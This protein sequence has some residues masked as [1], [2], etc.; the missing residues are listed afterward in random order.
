MKTCPQCGRELERVRQSENSPLN[1]DQFDA[2]KA[3]DWYCLAC[4]SNDRGNLP[5][6]YF[7]DYELEA[8]EKARIDAC[9]RV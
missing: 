8:F 6:S 3:G 7:W 1:R 4:P 2:V 9:F 5:Y